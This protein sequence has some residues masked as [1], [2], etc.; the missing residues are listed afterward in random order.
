VPAAARWAMGGCVVVVRTGLSAVGGRMG[1][2]GVR[3]GAARSAVSGCVAAVRSAVCVVRSRHG[4]LAGGRSGA[5]VVRGYAAIAGLC[6]AAVSGCGDDAPG[7]RTATG[8]L[9]ALSP[10]A[11]VSIERPLDGSRVRASQTPA[12]RLRARVRVAGATKRGG[13]VYLSA[14]CRPLRCDARATAGRDGRWTVSVTLATTR[15]SRFVTIDASSQPQVASTGSAVTTV[16]LAVRGGGGAR[17]SG[18]AGSP[19]ATAAPPPPPPPPVAQRPPSLPHDVLVIGDSLAVGMADALRASL[20]GWQVSIDAKISRPLATGMDILAAQ[21]GPPAILALSL[22][23]NDD[24]GATAALERAVRATAGRPGGCAVW[25]TI[26]RPPYN[27]VSYD[28]ANRVL[29]RLASDPRLNLR[30]V[31]WA[32]FVS[33]S[34]SFIAGDGVHATPAGYRARGEL[35]AQAI[36]SCAG[37]A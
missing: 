21:A 37:E 24:P 13:A 22:F 9:P 4:R 25:A 7:T 5:R 10:S 14:S 33:E 23:T 29:K 26:V 18:S 3:A 27:G 2:A 20:P 6:A 19:R 30:L 28:A 36:R 15:G 32:R 35:Y 31:D 16:E 12:G 34:P 1:F 17:R 11:P 8:A